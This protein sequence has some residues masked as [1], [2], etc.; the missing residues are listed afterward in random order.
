MKILNASLVQLVDMLN[1]HE[2]HDGTTLGEALSITRTA[3][4]KLIKKLADYGIKIESVKG[5][6][7][8]L[9]EP[10]TLLNKAQINK[11]LASSEINLEIYES[12]AS[13]NELL[14]RIQSRR[15]EP[16]LADKI[17]NVCIAEHQ[18]NGIGRFKRHWH[19]P[20]A[21]NIYLSYAHSFNK[22]VSELAGLSLAVSIAMLR[23]LE[24][25]GWSEDITIKWP[26]DIFYQHKKLAGNLI[27]VQAESNHQCT[28][29]IGI[30][31]NMN[32]LQASR[33]AITKDWVALRDITQHYINRNYFC[34]ELIKQLNRA[35]Q[36][37]EQTG[38][39][40]FMREWEKVD[41][42]KGNIITIKTQDKKMHGLAMGID[43]YGRLLLKMK[44]G[45]VNAYSSGDTSI[46]FIQ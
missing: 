22:D 42:L 38:L 13:T 41:Y 4:W 39:L 3:I 7:Y 6:G 24:N 21:Q 36:E 46:E 40:A 34:A 26:N 9:L 27:E 28:V 32:M 29:I 19:S 11:I 20:F 5:K 16:G 44:D 45:Q 23:S 35:L 37:F 33:K 8:K 1:D 15:L 18:T 30:G 10:L 14:K 31:F 12:L 2:Y 25:F 17:P 43:K